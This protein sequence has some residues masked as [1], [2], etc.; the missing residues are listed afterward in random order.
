[1]LCPIWLF[2][3]APWFRAQEFSEWFREE[4]SCDCYHFRFNIIIIIIIIKFCLPMNLAY[5]NVAL[6]R[7]LWLR[8]FPS[9]FCRWTV[10][11]PVLR[12]YLVI[13]YLYIQGV[14]GRVY[15]TSDE[16]F[17]A[18]FINSSAT[19]LFTNNGYRFRFFSIKPSSGW[20]YLRI[21]VANFSSSRLRD[22]IPWQ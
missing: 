5:W 21:I 12:E 19:Q 14:S 11:N 10:F 2:S 16:R 8:N 20:T 1:V 17:F 7:H 15:C 3:V 13:D 4:S 22:L 9:L 18:H 6:W